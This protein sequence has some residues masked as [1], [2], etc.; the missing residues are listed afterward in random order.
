MTQHPT[1]YDRFRALGLVLGSIPAA[2]V[3]LLAM[4]FFESSSARRPSLPSGC[5]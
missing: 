5:W 3:G 2:I 1:R 4:D